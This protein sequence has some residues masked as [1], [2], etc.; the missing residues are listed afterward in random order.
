MRP[1]ARCAESDPGGGFRE[2]SR[3]CLV[4]T[5][6]STTLAASDVTISVLTAVLVAITGYYAWQTRQ[7]VEELRRTRAVAVLPRLV[8]RMCDVGPT[9]SFIEVMNVGPGPAID[10][11]VDVSFVSRSE[12]VQPSQRRLQSSVLV[13]GESHQVIPKSDQGQG[14]PDT[15]TLAARFQRIEMTG[16]LTDALGVRHT[17]AEQLPDLEEWRKFRAQAHVRWIDPNAERRLAVEIG[18]ELDR[19]AKRLGD[20]MQAAKAADSQ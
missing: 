3:A 5:E 13:S 1:S 11:N 16:T 19:V 12:G 10:V 9:T 8:L 14:I 6:R 7:T 2:P 18:K 17:V 15:A 4:V 20:A